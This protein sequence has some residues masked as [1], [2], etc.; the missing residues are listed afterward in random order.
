MQRARDCC[1]ALARNLG[2]HKVS[3]LYSRPT[4]ASL[5]VHF[6]KK[7]LGQHDLRCGIPLLLW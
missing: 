6:V 7:P 3:N 4:N 2:C 5:L 1:R